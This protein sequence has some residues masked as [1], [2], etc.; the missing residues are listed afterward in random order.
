M[1]YFVNFASFFSNVMTIIA[2]GLA[3]FL[4]FKNRSKIKSAFNLL[5]SYTFQLSI[6]ELK[7]KIE[8]LNDYNVN[9]DEGKQ[10]IIEILH[11]IQGQFQGNEK[12]R[13][14][15]DKQ[16][17]KIKDFNE[18]PFNL[19]EPKKRSLVS[20]LRESLRNLELDRFKDLNQD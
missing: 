10:A 1:D 14:L 11:E 3:I 19:S 5:L 17:M 20:E 6:S 12:L 4:F 18:F 2:S 16:F 15:M 7:N 8:R 13:G 9:S